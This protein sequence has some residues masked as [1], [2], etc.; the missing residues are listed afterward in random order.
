MAAPYRIEWAATAKRDL[1]RLPEKVAGAIVEFIFAGLT[2]NPRRVGRELSLDLAGFH[3]AHRG[4]FRIVYR[5]DGRRRRV[6]VAAIDHRADI[7]RRR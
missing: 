3:A 2:E 1:G 7:Y 6:T 5:I 4:D